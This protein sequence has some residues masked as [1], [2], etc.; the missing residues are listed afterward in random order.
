LSKSWWIPRQPICRWQS[1]GDNLQ[2]IDKPEQMLTYSGFRRAIRGR[3]VRITAI[4]DNLFQF[5]HFLADSIENGRR[6]ARF[7]FE[8]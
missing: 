2:V 4:P 8:G 7:A 5:P 3:V 6:I 1:C